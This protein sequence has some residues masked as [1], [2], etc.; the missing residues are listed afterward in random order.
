MNGQRVLFGDIAVD[1]NLCYSS[2]KVRQRLTDFVVEYAKEH[3]E[4]DYIHLWIADN[5]N[6]HCECERCQTMTP[7]DWYVSLIQ[8]LDEKLTANKLPT[9]I[10]F[11]LY[12]EL[13]WPPTSP[14]KL[15]TDR[16]TLMF[17][18]FTRT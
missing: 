12:F 10:V 7:T 3:P 18:P 11:L 6:N 2:E 8:L 16:F 5:F 1:T 4:A 9:R 15:N 17:A 14:V 13:L